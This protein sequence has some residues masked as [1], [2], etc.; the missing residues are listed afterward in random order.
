MKTRQALT[1]ETAKR[2][3]NAG[4]KGKTKILD[5]FSGNTGYCR[6]YALHILANWE[7]MR[8]AEIDGGLVRLKAGETKKRKKRAGKPVY[9]PQDIQ[10]LKAVWDFFWQPCGKLTAPL[11]RAQMG[12]L[13]S[14]PEFG[15]TDAVRAHLLK[16]SPATI[17]RKLREEKKRLAV[18]GIS[19]TKPGALLRGQ[20]KVRTHYPFN[21]RE[22]GF[23]ETDTVH[24]CGESTGGEYNLTLTATDVYSGWVELRALLNKAHK[25]VVEGW[26]DIAGALPFPLLGI[27]SDN[28]GEFINKGLVAWCRQRAV[29]FTRSRPYK[30]ND[31]C[32]VE[33]KNNACVREYVG[34]YRFATPEER[35]AL[36]AVYRPLCPLLNYFMP[37]VKLVDKARVGAKVRK[38]YDTP[39]SPYQRLM[40]YPK[41]PEEVR[42]ELARRY[43]SYNP[44][45]LQ[46]EVNAAI[47]ALMAIHTQQAQTVS[48]APAVQVS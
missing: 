20:V 15:I 6:K 10:A 44:V 34:Y 12:F 19:G 46:R 32:H 1:N 16:I 36:A 21:E 11:L 8:V 18:R 9:T 37:S 27:D 24:N 23:F 4:R 3:R 43:Q 28:G 22:P 45:A 47:K 41:L 48:P 33:Q 35:D 14:V 13:V 30:K 29:E 39:V 31:N 17:D 42:A 7:K 38:V 40:G 25:W 5:E 2:Y 26:A